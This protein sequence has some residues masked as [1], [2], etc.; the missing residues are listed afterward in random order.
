MASS[1]PSAK[2]QQQKEKERKVILRVKLSIIATVTA[3]SGAVVNDLEIAKRSRNNNNSSSSS[4]SDF[5][6]VKVYPGLSHDAGSSAVV[7]VL[8]K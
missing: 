3:H 5:F 8:V 2:S 1:Q 6:F 4:S 7:G